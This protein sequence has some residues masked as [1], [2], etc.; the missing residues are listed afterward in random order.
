M[1]HSLTTVTTTVTQHY[2]RDHVTGWEAGLKLAKSLP[3]SHQ[4]DTARLVAASVLALPNN[5]QRKA[6]LDALFYS[7]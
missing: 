4:K 7:L 2:T 3:L 6:A 5:A 1:R